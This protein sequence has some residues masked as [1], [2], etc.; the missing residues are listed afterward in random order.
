MKKI[1]IILFL[2]IIL[3]SCSGGLTS[4]TSTTV[5]TIITTTQTYTT[6]TETTTQLTEYD[7]L[8]EYMTILESQEDFKN[9]WFEQERDYYEDFFTT[10]YSFKIEQD[11]VIDY[12]VQDLIF[13][14]ASIR[15]DRMITAIELLL[16]QTELIQ[17][18]EY[19]YNLLSVLYHIEGNQLNLTIEDD[20]YQVYGYY[21]IDINNDDKL[22]FDCL[23]LYYDSIFDE[24]IIA[25]IV[26]DEEEEYHERN[27]LMKS[28]SH[29][30][31]QYDYDYESNT[32]TTFL[33][34]SIPAINQ[35]D[36]G[37][38]E[39][40][41]DDQYYVVYSKGLV[42]EN[43][44]FTLFNDNHGSFNVSNMIITVSHVPEVFY[45]LQWNLMD[46]EGWDFVQNNK[47]YIG[48][49]SYSITPFFYDPFPYFGP[50]ITISEEFQEM[51][52]DDII[53][54]PL[55]VFSYDVYTLEDCQA[56][57]NRL[58]ILSEQFDI[59]EDTYTEF[60]VEKNFDNGF[61]DRFLEFITQEYLESIYKY[62]D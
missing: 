54:T 4:E 20:L 16:D 15:A 22:W 17:N 42:Y 47:V 44:Y 14:E 3:T 11:E 39:R 6:T 1:W 28:G 7:L 43:K 40:H 9:T 50:E 34:T 29:H 25:Y 21:R 57:L 53:S 2:S 60:G 41:F 61:L 36:I 33:T 24:N 35:Y 8:Q 23:E 13:H 46:I 58:E 48:N 52:N 12:D 10:R 30:F 18:H 31:F 62:L 38:S 51:Y 27:V 56:P 26:Y 19:S 45:T 32:A 49:Q 5:S 59:T 37:R 55:D